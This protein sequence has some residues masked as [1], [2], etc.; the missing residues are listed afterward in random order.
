MKQKQITIQDVGCDRKETYPLALTTSASPL[1]PKVNAPPGP[2][3]RTSLVFIYMRAAN[4]D[5]KVT[6]KVNN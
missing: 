1:G 5:W 2:R 3:T 6:D 4:S